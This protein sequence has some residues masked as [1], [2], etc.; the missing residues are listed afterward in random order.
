[1]LRAGGLGSG[2]EL[3]VLNMGEPVRIKDLAE[4]LIQLSGFSL[5]EIPVVFTELRPGEKLSETLTSP[6]ETSRPS[7]G[8]LL[9][10]IE[11]VRLGEAQLEVALERLEQLVITDDHVGARAALLAIARPAAVDPDAAGPERPL[12]AQ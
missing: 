11:P 5:A 1:V 4:D 12:R 2:G 3:F 6:A 9:H 8:D 7:Y 10:S